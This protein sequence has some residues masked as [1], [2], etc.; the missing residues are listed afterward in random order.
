MTRILCFPLLL[1]FTLPLF[2]QEPPVPAQTDPPIPAT[3]P[4]PAS[5]G[6]VLPRDPLLLMQLRE[7]LARELQQTQQTLSV[8]NPNDTLLVETLK[9]QQARLAKEIRDITQQM[10][11]ASLGDS[12]GIGE[13]LPGQFQTNPQSGR[14]P[15]MPPTQGGLIV[16]EMPQTMPSGQF[17]GQP[18]MS[19]NPP[20]SYGSNPFYPNPPYSPIPASPYYGSTPYGI[21]NWSDQGVVSWGPKLPEE[22]TG[23]KQSIEALKKEVSDLKEMVKTLETQIQLLNRN[24]LLI[25]KVRENG[26]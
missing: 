4:E 25:E 21:P 1:A 19:Q 20:A 7:R 8:I 6:Q 15:P 11:T 13:R 5:L 22:L 9:T 23:V 26:N 16:P 3:V 17:P 24:F 14:T 2:A 12:P 18:M 10:Q